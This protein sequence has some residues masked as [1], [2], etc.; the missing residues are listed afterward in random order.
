MLHSWRTA[1]YILKVSGFF[2][3]A[4]VEKYFVY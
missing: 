2:G 1:G 3:K 4:E